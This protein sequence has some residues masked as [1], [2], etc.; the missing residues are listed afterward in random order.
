MLDWRKMR[1]GK[2]TWIRA[3]KYLIIVAALLSI[4]VAGHPVH[5]HQCQ[6]TGNDA[7]AI[8]Q[9]NQCK[10]D[11][12]ITGMHQ[13]ADPPEDTETLSALRAENKLLRLQLENIKNCL[14]E[15]LK[16]L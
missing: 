1:I 15:I 9:Y 16:D 11:L 3:R 6:L 14:F 5:A 7:N 13:Q 10:A 2:G 8:S 4:S 12:M